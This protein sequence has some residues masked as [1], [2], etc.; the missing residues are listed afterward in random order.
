MAVSTEP[1]RSRQGYTLPSALGPGSTIALVSPADPAAHLYP[2]RIERASLH[3]ARRG[4]QLRP[5]PRSFAIRADRPY[6][7]GT[8]EERARDIMDAFEDP[9][10][11]AIWASIGGMN[12]DRVLDRLDFSRIARSPKVLLGY[13]D[14]TCLLNAVSQTARMVTFHGPH[15]TVEWGGQAVDPFTEAALW[16]V[17]ADTSPAGPLPQATETRL[18]SWPP[19]PSLPVGAGPWYGNGAGAATGAL[20]GGNL[21]T[22][23]RLA[24]TPWWPRFAGKVLFWEDVGVPE[25]GL[26]GMLTQLRLLGVWDAVAAV[27]I[28]KVV[29]PAEDGWFPPDR[30]ADLVQDVAGR[31]LPIVAG[32]DLGHTDPMLTFPVG[33]EVRVDADLATIDI[34]EPAVHRA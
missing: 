32:V 25:H 31:T 34:L 2:E 27:V 10:I 11:D 1:P 30:V 23:L 29:T 19:G 21:Q 16:R 6:L 14:T 18:E 12:A 22:L 26:D 4:M 20:I 28:G 33:V 24:G 3:L 15:L 9:S 7:A 5:M 13:S 17:V 8:D